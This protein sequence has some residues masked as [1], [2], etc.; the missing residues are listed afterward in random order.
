MSLDFILDAGGRPHYIDSNPRLAETGNGLAAGVNLPELLVRVSLGQAPRECRVGSS[1]VR[2]FMG[3]QGLLKAAKSSGTR[4]QVVRTIR[5][6]VRGRG[7][8]THGSEE[9]TP[10]R[11]DLRSAVPV[12]LVAGALLVQPRLWRKLSSSTVDAYAATP[13]VV[14][15]ARRGVAAEVL[16]R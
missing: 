5:D 7:V 6:L 4:R 12:A 10:T 3:I 1:G 8:F 11:K 16:A 2:S 13:A 15:F 9:L 14:A